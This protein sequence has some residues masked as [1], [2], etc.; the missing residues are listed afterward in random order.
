M[1][2]QQSWAS[3]FNVDAIC[4]KAAAKAFS[5]LP[6]PIWAAMGLTA[7][8]LKPKS[9]VVF[10]LSKGKEFPYPAE[11]PSGFMSAILYAAF[12][13]SMSSARASA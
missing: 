5:H 1:Y 6:L 10:S 12:S 7:N 3:L 13:I 11:L 2:R 8:V 4:P 9:L